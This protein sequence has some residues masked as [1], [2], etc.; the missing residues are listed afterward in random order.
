[1]LKPVLVALCFAGS[2]VWAREGDRPVIEPPQRQQVVLPRDIVPDFA[3]AYRM[4]GSPK[5]VLLWNRTI[6]DQSQLGMM[7]K[8][9]TRETGT[10]GSNRSEKS[11]IGDADSMTV[12]DE[13]RKFDRTKTQTKMNVA[14]AEPTRR[15]GLGERHAVMVERAF[16][17]EMN[18]AGVSFVDRA[19]AMRATAASK[20]RAGGDQHLIETD[21]IYGFADL[22]MEVVWIE[23]K[24][25]PAG[26]AF[27]VKTKSLKTGQEVSSVYTRGIGWRPPRREG[28]W[29]AGKDGYEY[30]NA[31][32]VAGP[33]LDDVGAAIS[34]DV[35]RTL[36]G[37][38]PLMARGRD[39]KR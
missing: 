25:A 6:S 29:V 22:V 2:L 16:V 34:H 30:Q 39:V 11:T 9:V 24:D 3:Q 10:S 35:M 37:V 1:M 14:N 13:D 31:P 20:H 5:I 27:D 21:A 28:G 4:A 7:E 12:T 15:I 33:G 18:R 36:G 32:P 17:A 19:L 23:D 26:Y 8:K 38:L